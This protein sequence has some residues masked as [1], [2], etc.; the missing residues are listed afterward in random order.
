MN[1]VAFLINLKECGKLLEEYEL[2]NRTNYR[3]VNIST[4]KKYSDEFRVSAQKDNYA[5][6][7][8]VG[9][10]KDDYDY[11]LRDGSY[12]QFS[13][14]ENDVD[15]V[16]RMA[17]YPTINRIS[18]E[19]FLLEFLE[20]SIEECGG[21]FIEDYQ[22]YLD[23]QEINV[24][25]PVRYDYNSKIYQKVIHSA[26]HIHFGYEENIRVPA[27]K[28]L[29]PTAF[30]KIVLQYFYYNTWKK[31]VKNKEDN[32]FISGSEKKDIDSVYWE[33]EDRKIPYIS[34]T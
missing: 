21:A 9:S 10:E 26:S 19:E 15:F 17:F 1:K 11:I 31:K 12:F 20:L 5:K 27:N 34:C 29:F 6:T 16:I 14:D 22:Q 33:S 7:F 25:T 23:E 13:F 28:I 18:Y 8:I 32:C 2:L 24:V 4:Y 30:I 3:N